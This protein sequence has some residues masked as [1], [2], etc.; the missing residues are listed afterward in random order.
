MLELEY[1]YRNRE[2]NNIMDQL[3]PVYK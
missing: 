2:I 1:K 3:M